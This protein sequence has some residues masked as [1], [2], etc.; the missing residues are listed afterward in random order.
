MSKE[1]HPMDI[2]YMQAQELQLEPI[3]EYICNNCTHADMVP[4][5]PWIVNSVYNDD[6]IIQIYNRIETFGCVAYSNPFGRHW[7]LR[8]PLAVAVQC[9]RPIIAAK[10]CEAIFRW[11]PFS[12]DHVSAI[13][14][15]CRT[16]NMRI[17]DA[18]IKTRGIDFIK[19]SEIIEIILKEDYVELMDFCLKHKLDRRM[20]LDSG[21]SLYEAAVSDQ[22]RELLDERLIPPTLGDR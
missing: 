16:R 12:I 21:K 8:E 22:M 15:A 10:I 18:Y 11:S 2:L 13:K 5:I 19:N 4:I 1:M 17:I 3:V 14:Q 20:R 6:Y 7:L 9:N